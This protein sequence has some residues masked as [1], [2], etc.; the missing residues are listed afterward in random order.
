MGLGVQALGTVVT[1]EAVGRHLVGLDHVG[2]QLCLGNLL[3]IN[4]N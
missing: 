1:E 4:Y 2:P 3:E